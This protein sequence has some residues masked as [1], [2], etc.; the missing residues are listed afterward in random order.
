MTAQQ[1]PYVSPQEMHW[2]FQ[3]IKY[4]MNDF[5]TFTIPDEQEW[6]YENDWFYKKYDV[7]VRIVCLDGTFLVAIRKKI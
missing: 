1:I 4:K 2:D 6:W 3:E 7:V 5:H